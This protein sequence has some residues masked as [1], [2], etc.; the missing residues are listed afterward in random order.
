MIRPTARRPRGHRFLLV[1]AVALLAAALSAMAPATSG[2]RAQEW[3]LDAQHFDA[4]RIQPISQGAN[5]VVA[6]VDSGVDASQ[7]DLS[8]RVLPGVNLVSDGAVDG[9]TDVSPDSHGTSIAALIAGTGTADGGAGILGLAPQAM[10]LPVRVSQGSQVDQATLAEGITW[11]ADH[12]ARVINV[13][14]GAPEPDPR[15][16]DAVAYAQKHGCVVVASAGNS[17][18]A[19]DPVMY[20]AGFPGVV[21]VTGSTT[22]HTFWTAGESGSFVDLA[23]PAE[24]I[25]SVSDTGQYLQS[26]GTSYSAAYVSATAAL[27]ASHYPKLTGAQIIQRLILTASDARKP[28]TQWGY[29]EIDPLAAV[30]SPITPLSD[31]NP[32]MTRPATARGSSMTTVVA[33]FG[34]IGIVL[35]TGAALLVNRRRRAKTLRQDQ[36]PRPQS[37]QTKQTGS[38]G[39]TSASAKPKSRR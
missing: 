26:N 6:V 11:A 25:E 24:D 13:S 30:T 38:R 17:A 7:P 21:A 15:V 10:I 32:L 31:T 20:P 36:A 3:P 39:S 29:G 19:G 12:G 16:A 2:P 14:M 9:R 5:V 28:N 27:I 35:L 34:V 4:A 18:Q 8:G 23:A 33:I 22:S 1:T 37:K